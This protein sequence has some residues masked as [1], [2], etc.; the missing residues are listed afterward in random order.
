MAQVIALEDVS[1]VTITHIAEM[2]RYGFGLCNTAYGARRRKIPFE[3]GNTPTP[4]GYATFPRIGAVGSAYGPGWAYSESADA[5]KK[6]AFRL[7]APAV[8][9]GLPVRVDPRAIPDCRRV[10]LPVIWPCRT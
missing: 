7:Q 2:N 9:G 1:P 4:L 3:S 5:T 10:R 6:A 8:P